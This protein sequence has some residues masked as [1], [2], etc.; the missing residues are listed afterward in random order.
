MALA[1]GDSVIP[2]GVFNRAYGGEAD[3]SVGTL[4]LG[5]LPVGFYNGG[6]NIV[7]WNNGQTS[8]RAYDDLNL[9]LVTPY[10]GTNLLGKRVSLAGVSPAFRGV[11]VQQFNTE[12]NGTAGSG[13]Q[14]PVCVVKAEK[15]FYIAL[16]GNLVEVN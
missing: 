8:E 10:T 5:E 1:N 7:H 13:D 6:T 9:R 16:P 4:C 15:F 12:L 2:A 11:V 3:L 14:E